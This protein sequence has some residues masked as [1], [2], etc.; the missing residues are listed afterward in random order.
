[1]QRL[2]YDNFSRHRNFRLQ[3]KI[4]TARKNN[5]SAAVLIALS[6]KP[7]YHRSAMMFPS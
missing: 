2:R 6:P 5:L 7:N 1:M 3:I 4:I